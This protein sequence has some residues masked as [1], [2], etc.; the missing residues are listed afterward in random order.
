MSDLSRLARY[1]TVKTIVYLLTG[2]VRAVDG[3][4]GVWADGRRH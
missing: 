4:R 3:D 1:M 2:A